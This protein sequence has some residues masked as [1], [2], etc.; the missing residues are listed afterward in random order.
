ML[1]GEARLRYSSALKSYNMAAFELS[2]KK[3]DLTQRIKNKL[4]DSEE[5]QKQLDTVEIDYEKVKE[6]YN[7]YKQYTDKLMEQWTTKMDEV[8]S[9]Q[10]A[11]AAEEY[12][13]EM[14][15]IMLVARRIMKGDIV[16][17]T[18][19]KKLM[20]FDDKLYQMAKNMQAM[21]WLEEKRHE[22][23]KSLW[24]EEE[25]RQR[26]DAM[27]EADG[28]E[29]NIGMDAPEIVDVGDVMSSGAIP[30]GEV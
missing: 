22:K 1:V 29:V 14:S 15:K 18:D 11:E 6:K 21:A 9:E 19:E 8:S 30:E 28:Q 23:H 10:Q 3:E 2:K 12:C 5:L 17:M 24:E 27:E 26:V 25:K 4:G 13:K 20:E 16:P 7:E